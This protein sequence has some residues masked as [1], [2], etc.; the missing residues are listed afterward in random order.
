MSNGAQLTTP[1]LLFDQNLS[2]R[3][4]SRLTD[5]SPGAL[6]VSQLGLDRA[7]DLAVWEYARV[8]D[9]TLVT[10][11]ADF[12]DLSVLRGAPPKVLWLRLG[13]CATTDIEQAL[14]RGYDAIVAFFQNPT[15]GILEII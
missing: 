11:D 1:T 2:P 6:H 3:L 13:N 14:R 15:L 7:S 12:S 9:C 5:I 4:V 10:K 8:H